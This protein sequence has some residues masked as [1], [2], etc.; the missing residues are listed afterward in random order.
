MNKVINRINNRHTKDRKNDNC[1]IN[2]QE[3]IRDK[4]T[5]NTTPPTILAYNLRLYMRQRYINYGKP[6]RS[7]RSASFHRNKNNTII[8]SA[9]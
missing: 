4:S 6:A 3:P 5:I 8:F 1:V 9:K 7:N 2:N